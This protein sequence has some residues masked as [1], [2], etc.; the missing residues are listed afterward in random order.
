VTAFTSHFVFEFKS[1]L[2]NSTA[3]LMNYL[4]PLGFYVLMGSVM[5]QIYPGFKEILI[6][7]LIIFAIMA[8]N[9]LGLPGPL[10]ESRE[11]GIYRSFK[12]NGVPAISIL[13]I[14]TLSTIFHALLASAVI[15]LTAVP[16]FEAQSPVNWFNLVW[17]TLLTALTFGAI[18]ALIG[19]IARSSRSVV[20][21]SQIIFLPSMLLGGLMMPLDVLPESV[22]IISGLLPTTYAIQS[23]Q[24][25]AFDQPTL[26]DPII[27]VLTLAASCILTFGLAIYLFNWDSQNR[28]Q[29]GHP[30][31]GL[32]VLVP[33][34]IAIILS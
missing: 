4:F 29:R 20:L 3:M 1:G 27:S 25:L 28:T 32:L 6:P 18:G 5:T 11:A 23:F 19:V 24:A 15:A 31:L 16:F 14:P 17:I 9:L 13:S 12:I 2:R 33:Y 26:I 30:L 22:R 10:V 34:V 8:S 7:S 21:L